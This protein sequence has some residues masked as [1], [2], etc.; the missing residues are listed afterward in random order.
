MKTEMIPE[1]TFVDA[2]SG[3]ITEAA[4]SLAYL[5]AAI[6]RDLPGWGWLVRSIDAS[7]R[8]EGYFANVTSPDF[9]QFW[10]GENVSHSGSTNHATA[11]SP[12]LALMASFEAALARSEGQ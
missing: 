9:E 10:D 5:I 12:H 1:P 2:P 3:A 4:P 6:E 7:E 8:E 11:K